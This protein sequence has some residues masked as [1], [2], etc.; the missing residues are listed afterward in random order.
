M[1]NVS[2]TMGYNKQRLYRNILVD[3]GLE[4]VEARYQ[5]DHKTYQFDPKQF[6][7]FVDR[8][9]RDTEAVFSLRSMGFRLVNTVQEPTQQELDLNQMKEMSRTD[10]D[11]FL[12]ELIGGILG[13]PVLVVKGEETCDCPGCTQGMSLAEALRANYRETGTVLG[14]VETKTEAILKSAA[15]KNQNKPSDSELADMHEKALAWDAKI[16]AATEQALD[17]FYQQLRPASAWACWSYLEKWKGHPA[18]LDFR[19]KKEYAEIP[20]KVLFTMAQRLRAQI[21]DMNP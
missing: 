19:P 15:Y 12:S 18:W 8:A 16:T 6:V 1:N 2:L 3:L 13:V 9:L 4:S 10:P 7:A 20:V 21:M 11:Q 17:F 5:S 14:N